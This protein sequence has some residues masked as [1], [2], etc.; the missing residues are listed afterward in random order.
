[1]F[2]KHVVTNGY[3]QEY[4]QSESSGN[5]LGGKSHTYVTFYALIHPSSAK[6][7]SPLTPNNQDKYLPDL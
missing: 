2:H 6:G 5:C 3:P 7:N 1:M 4:V